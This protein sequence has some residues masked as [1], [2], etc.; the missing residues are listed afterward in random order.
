MRKTAAIALFILAAALLDVAGAVQGNG[1]RYAGNPVR[2]AAD[3][4]AAAR[5]NAAGHDYDRDDNGLIEVDSLARLDAVRWD[6]DG[7]GAADAG[8]AADDAASYAAAFPYPAAGMGCPSAGCIGYELTQSLDFDTDGDGATYRVASHGTVAG[9]AGDAY[10]NGGR[11]WTPIGRRQNAYDAVFDGKGY[12]IANLFI[13]TTQAESIGL[14]GSIGTAGAVRNLGLLDVQVRYSSNSTVASEIGGLLGRSAGTVGHCYATGVVAGGGKGISTIG[15][16]VGVLRAGGTLRNSHAA[17]AVS[18]TGSAYASRDRIGGLAGMVVHPGSAIIASYAAGPVTTG[19]YGRVGGLVGTLWRGGTITSSYAAGAVAGGDRSS[20]G[21]LVGLLGLEGGDITASYAAGPVTGGANA[22][23]GGL[24]GHSD[25]RGRITDSYAIGAVSARAD[26]YIGGVIAGGGPETA[27]SYWNPGSTGQADSDTGMDE[28]TRN[29]QSPTTNNGIYE[30]W[31]TTQWDFGTARQYPAVKHN[32]ELVPGQRQTALQVDWNRPVV[33]EP[34][35]AGLHLIPMPDDGVWQ[36]QRSATGAEWT[37]IADAAAAVYV[38]VA[39]D[40]ADGGQ[41]LRAQVTF[42]LAGKTQTVTTYNT[43]KVVAERMVN[44]VAGTAVFAPD[45]AV[46]RRL[47]YSI[48]DAGSGAGAGSG[49]DDSNGDN[50][51]VNGATWRWQRCADR[52]MRTEC[53]YLPAGAVSYTITA[54]DVG[55]YLRAY[56]Y[57]ADADSGEWRRATTPVLGPVVD[58]DT[59]G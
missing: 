28:T 57:Y 47:E 34:V 49:D 39:A 55:Q 38:P 35:A 20:V 25:W 43:A 42:T 11:G 9:D 58:P 12:V 48:P 30:D 36:W 33:G 1:A 59:D 6:L 27:N 52:G 13:S 7:D 37:D 14:F 54:D 18:G 32:G 4:N 15:G 16:L 3:T 53:R 45:A 50:A 40:A 41:F 23:A 8:S 2:L 29:M 10:Y 44:E 21:G 26:S 51:G 24:V 22:G 5:V 19:D 56:V 31:Q 17:V 46:G